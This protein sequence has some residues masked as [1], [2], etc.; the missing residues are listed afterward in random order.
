MVTKRAT[1]KPP[2]LL[3]KLIQL[4]KD[5]GLSD[6]KF[7]AFLGVGRVVWYSTRKQDRPIGKTLLEAITKAYPELNADVL[8]YLRSGDHG[9][10][11]PV[12]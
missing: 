6:Y 4:Q 8:N 2:I 5:S 1:I 12:T 11:S 3:E 9:N 7:A 10:D